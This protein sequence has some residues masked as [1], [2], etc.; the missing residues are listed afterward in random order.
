[1]E[2]QTANQFDADILDPLQKGDCRHVC[3]G[4]GVLTERQEPLLG[5]KNELGASQKLQLLFELKTHDGKETADM[6]SLEVEWRQQ[7][8]GAKTTWV[9]VKITASFEPKSA[10]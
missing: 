10:C 7:T 2:Y 5:S 6:R 4:S 9:Q 1:M 3:P 8:M